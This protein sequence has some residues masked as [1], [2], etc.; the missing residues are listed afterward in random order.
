M[1][2]QTIEILLVE[3][4]PDDRELALHAL[5]KHKLANAIETVP[6]GAAALDFIQGRGKYAD[7]AQAPRPRLILLDLKLPKVDGIEVLR[8]LKSN[9]ATRAIPVVVMTSSREEQDLVRSYEL[10]VNSYVVKPVDF[11]Q[12]TDAVRQLGLYWMLLNQLPSSSRA[13]ESPR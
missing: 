4:N 9:P 6:D 13:P 8:Q 2:D 3:D 10:G 5:R 1:N 12:F 11:T 7:R